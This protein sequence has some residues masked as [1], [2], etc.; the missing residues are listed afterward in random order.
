MNS[1]I[2]SIT[3]KSGQ[4]IS[5][6]IVFIILARILGP[7]D[8]GVA[9]IVFVYLFLV[10]VIVNG[11]VD[12]VVSKQ[13]DD[14]KTLSSIFWVVLFIGFTF[15]L[16]CYLISG[17]VSTFFKD[18]IYKSIFVQ[19]SPVPTLISLTTLPSIIST[20]L[21]DFRTLAK[22]SLVSSLIGGIAGIISA[23]NNQGAHAIIHQQIISYIVSNIII[24]R[25]ITWRPNIF[26]SNIGLREVFLPGFAQV[27]IGILSW[28]ESQ[29]PRIIIATTLGPAML[30]FYSMALR[31]IMSSLEVLIYAPLAVLFPKMAKISNDKSAQN[32]VFLKS[33]NLLYFVVWPTIAIAIAL[34]NTY[35]TYI[36]GVKWIDS[37]LILQVALLGVI[38][39]S[40]IYACGQAFRANGK[41]ASFFRYRLMMTIPG[42]AAL[43]LLFIPINLWLYLLSV[44]L[45]SL[46]CSLFMLNEISKHLNFK[47]SKE[48]KT[49]SLTAICATLTGL[50]AYT[51]NSILINYLEWWIVLIIATIL[52]YLIHFISGYILLKKTTRTYF[53]LARRLIKI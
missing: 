15:S 36:F 11:L 4:Q 16:I 41:T 19:F 33:I 5:S 43:S 8:Y 39:T 7:S 37:I 3:E 52:G 53:E 26:F 35:I 34:P 20:R 44:F 9:S 27:H 38:P 50:T 14:Q 24:W 29:L 23:L 49:I 6:F 40:I 2:W 47:L 51:L 18:N 1:V 42:I 10:T 31:I 25:S 45:I 32:D 48:L 30:G 46:S 13:I 12:G 17:I 21:L 22:R 28:A